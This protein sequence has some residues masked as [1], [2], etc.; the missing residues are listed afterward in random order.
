MSHAVE[1]GLLPAA[2]DH[3][4]H[5]AFV[6]WIVRTSSADGEWRVEDGSN[7]AFF[8]S[9]RGGPHRSAHVVGSGFAED[10]ETLFYV[11]PRVQGVG[12]HSND[13]LTFG[14]LE[15]GVETGGD[16]ALWITEHMHMRKVLC[17]AL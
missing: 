3:C 4:V 10:I 5:I 12:V 13:D 16:D 8:V 2:I 14:F 11:I 7:R 6:I 15:S 17:N 1:D 9:G